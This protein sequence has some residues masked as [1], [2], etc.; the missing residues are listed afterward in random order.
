[1]GAEIS[2]HALPNH[3]RIIHIDS[4]DANPFVYHL[5]SEYE[6]LPNERK[7]NQK[8]A[9]VREYRIYSLGQGILIESRKNASDTCTFK[10][11]PLILLGSFYDIEVCVEGFH[12]D[13]TSQFYSFL[14]KNVY[15]TATPPVLHLSDLLLPDKMLEHSPWTCENKTCNHLNYWSIPICKGCSSHNMVE[16]LRQLTTVPLLSIPLSAT[17]AVLTCGKACVTEA[18]EDIVEAITESTL[19]IVH[20]ALTPVLVFET[21][22]CIVRHIPNNRG[23]SSAHLIAI[24]PYQNV[25]REL[26]KLTSAYGIKIEIARKILNYYLLQQNLPALLPA[27]KRPARGGLPALRAPLR[28]PAVHRVPAA[29]GGPVPQVTVA[30]RVPATQGVVA[31]ADNADNADH[32]E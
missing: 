22:T 30:L 3:D 24:Y 11:H 5:A 6:D 15:C 14:T 20:I 1:M 31:A 16:T 8:H 17:V 21:L 29:L 9:V 23:K 26:V 28:V 10:E 18:P 19:V 27:S 25:C 2:I 7:V 4:I 13:G 12:G 32:T